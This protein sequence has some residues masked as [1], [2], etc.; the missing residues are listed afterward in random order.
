MF[1]LLEVGRRKMVAFA[2]V[3][4]GEGVSK[5]RWR[6]EEG[7]DPWKWGRIPDLRLQM[8]QGDE[9]CVTRVQQ[10]CDACEQSATLL[11][12]DKAVQRLL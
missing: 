4:G 2:L 8:N 5:R 1:P 9:A 11:S 10:A 7:W 3:G 12:R 6:R